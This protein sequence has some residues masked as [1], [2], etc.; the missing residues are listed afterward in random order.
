[1]EEGVPIG[2]EQLTVALAAL[3]KLKLEAALLVEHLNAVVVRV[4]DDDVVLGVDGDTRRL[5]KLTF[6]NAE[7]AELAVIDHLLT[8]DLRTRRVHPAQARAQLHHLRIGRR[9]ESVL[10]AQLGDRVASLRA[11]R[12]R[13]RVLLRT[14]RRPLLVLERRRLQKKRIFSVSSCNIL[15]RKLKGDA[16][17]MTT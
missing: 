7:L 6:H 2:I 12:R 4:G 13:S 17:T 14:A 5:R 10:H 8:F 9:S 15:T 3:S 16:T 1:M 11:R